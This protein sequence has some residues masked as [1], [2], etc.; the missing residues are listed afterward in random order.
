MLTE[1]DYLKCF[2]QKA[3]KKRKAQAQ[4]K[5]KEV[6][7]TYW[8]SYFFLLIPMSPFS[9]IFFSISILIYSNARGQGCT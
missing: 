9:R 4:V 6:E 8:I 7:R 2:I 1:N 3:P 5:S